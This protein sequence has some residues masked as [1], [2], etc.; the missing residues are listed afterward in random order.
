MPTNIYRFGESEPLQSRVKCECLW[1]GWFFVVAESV[2]ARR[3]EVL[4]AKLF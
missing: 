4:F 1:C 2:S 3:G